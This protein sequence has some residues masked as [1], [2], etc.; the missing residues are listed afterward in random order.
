MSLI[1]LIILTQSLVAEKSLHLSSES[2]SDT[3][4][5]TT[6]NSACKTWDFVVPLSDDSTALHIDSGTYSASVTI[7]NVASITGESANTTAIQYTSTSSSLIY[8]TYDNDIKL[9]NFTYVTPHGLDQRFTYVY[10]CDSLELNNIN[11]NGSGNIN[12]GYGYYDLIFTS[13]TD[14]IIIKNMY[15]YDIDNSYSYSVI[16]DIRYTD[17]VSIDNILVINTDIDAREK[18]IQFFYGDETDGDIYFQNVVIEHYSTSQILKITDSD[19]CD[20]YLINITLYSVYGEEL[21]DFDDNYLCN[22]FFNNVYAN[23]N[24]KNLSAG[25]LYYVENNYASFTM[26][27]VIF[28]N[29]VLSSASA[30]GMYFGDGHFSTIYLHNVSFVNLTSSGGSESLQY[31]LIYIHDN[32]DVIIDQCL[33]DQNKKFSAMIHCSGSYADVNVT[34]SFFGE[35]VVGGNGK[36]TSGEAPYSGI[37]L[38]NDARVT[39]WLENNTFHGNL[40]ISYDSTS[41]V[42]EKNNSIVSGNDG[43]NDTNSDNAC[44]PNSR[45]LSNDGDDGDIYNNN[46]CTIESNPCETWSHTVTQFNEMDTLYIDSGNYDIDEEM[47]IEHNNY[48]L[49]TVNYTIIGNGHSNN[50]EKRNT[51]LKTDSES[52]NVFHISGSPNTASNNKISL[53]ISE[54][55]YLPKIFDDSSF[56][57]FSY[58]SNLRLT[59]IAVDGSKGALSSVRSVVGMIYVTHVAVVVVENMTIDDVNRP[60]GYG[61]Y[62]F[63]IYESDAVIL[64]NVN[65]VFNNIASNN[66]YHGYFAFLGENSN[67][68][69]VLDNILIQDYALN[70]GFGMSY[71][72]YSSFSFN[73]IFL[74]SVYGDYIFWSYSNLGQSIYMNNLTLNKINFPSGTINDYLMY[75]RSDDNGLLN[76]RNSI[77]ANTRMSSSA[78]AFGFVYSSPVAVTFENVSFFNLTTDNYNYGLIYVQSSVVNVLL[79]DC[80]FLSNKNFAGIF[81]CG[82]GSHCNVSIKNSL[83]EGNDG[84]C[85]NDQSITNGFYFEDASTGM[86]SIENST[87]IGIPWIHNN[88]SFSFTLDNATQSMMVETNK[89]VS[90]WLCPA[91]IDIYVS[92]NRYFIC[93]S[94]TLNIS[95]KSTQTR[96]K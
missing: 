30:Y 53:E 78:I 49:A 9:S 51:F 64:K 90:N 29:Y 22:T 84:L 24:G 79:H 45:Y 66:Y 72:V 42:I 55:I 38:E 23:G 16:F 60:D 74:D 14:D 65:Y 10:Y 44:L 94:R 93:L 47:Y 91:G 6:E 46:N 63:V 41:T 1:L 61:D 39:L 69:A 25:L 82:Y 68:S 4:N 19:R 77:F 67:S 56:G 71:N 70:R 87:F 3:N 81:H 2:G 37:Y 33:F 5:C 12:D 26:K 96:D 36:C 28:S 32:F 89:N 31:G 50:N 75:F 88:E 43:T 8:V 54:V 92:N 7:N 34:N 58:L 21:F 62:V 57:H 52:L 20:M 17:F 76:I 27:N 86:V 18:T 40:M 48:Y 85:H 11:I 83:F 80:N 95:I 15:I 59:E 13:L 35:N 73:N